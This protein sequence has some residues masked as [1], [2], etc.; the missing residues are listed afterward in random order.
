MVYLFTSEYN[1]VVC[2]IIDWLNFYKI[3][4]RRLHNYVKEFEVINYFDEINSIESKK[5]NDF[6]FFYKISNNIEYEHNIKIKNQLFYE[7]LFGFFSAIDEKRKFGNILYN[8]SVSKV[9]VLKEAKKLDILIP[10]TLI[11]N[12]KDNLKYFLSKHGSIITKPCHELLELKFDK[13]VYRSYTS[14]VTL[15]DLEYLSETFGISMFQQNVEK[16]CDIKTVYLNGVFYSQAIFSQKNINTKI[17]FR[18]YDFNKMSRMN[19]FKIPN[20]LE[21]KLEALLQKF[22]LKFAILD[23]ILDTNDNLYFLEINVDGV[24]DSI[25]LDCNYYIEKKIVEIFYGQETK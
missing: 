16:K 7:Y 18:K 12:K 25:S 19:T 6:Y 8:N 14:E 23:L 1:S 10:D 17:D 2:R 22:T 21:N 5:N 4:Y 24:Y 9:K 15:N 20:E 11:T 13:K 3:E